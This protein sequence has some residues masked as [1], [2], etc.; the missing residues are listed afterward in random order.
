MPRICIFG[1]SITWGKLDFEGGGWTDRLKRHLLE[2]DESH[3]VYNLG[4]TGNNTSL[5]L[6]RMYTECKARLKSKYQKDGIII[7]SL[8]N[9][10]SK[11][12]KNKAP[13]IPIPL[14]K[15]NIKKI[16]KI[17]KNSEYDFDCRSRQSRRRIYRNAA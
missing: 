14:F 1:A 4:I 15:K 13:S 5:L 12:V 7:I 3:Q 2:I 9:N 11:L 17:R 16:R 6:E 8:G 10:D